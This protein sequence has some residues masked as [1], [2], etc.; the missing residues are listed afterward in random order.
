M[1]VAAKAASAARVVGGGGGGVVG[2]GVGGGASLLRQRRRRL[3]RQGGGRAAPP[4][5]SSRASSGE[6]EAPPAGDR[7]P[8][9]IVLVTAIVGLVLTA[10]LVSRSV[11]AGSGIPRWGVPSAVVLLLVLAVS[12]RF[13]AQMGQLSDDET[14]TVVSGLLL[15]V[16]KAFDYRQEEVIYD[17]LARTTSGELLT[18]VYLETRRSLELANQGGA[19]AKVRTLEVTE[20]TNEPVDRNGSFRSRASWNVYGSVG[21]WGHVH[22]RVNRYD[23]DLTVEVI[24]GAWRI[25]ELDVLQEERLPTTSS[26]ATAANPAGGAAQA[27]EAR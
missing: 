7:V 11:R 15:N 1:A 2:G 16:Y 6:V 22:Q 26:P 8:A 19:R 9:L 27:G 21:H 13:V 3:R 10:L 23:A 14:R 24:D 20:A 18:D 5:S 4:R 12:A 17:A 25:T